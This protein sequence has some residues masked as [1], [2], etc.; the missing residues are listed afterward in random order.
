MYKQNNEK[1]GLW[2][3]TS[4]VVNVVSLFIAIKCDHNSKT[5]SYSFTTMMIRYNRKRRSFCEV[6]FLHQLSRQSEK[7]KKEIRGGLYDSLIIISSI[8]QI[9]NGHI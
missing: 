5:L 2:L 9:L 1:N 6:I 7:A 4:N 8:L 3:N